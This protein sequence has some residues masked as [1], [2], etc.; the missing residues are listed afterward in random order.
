MKRRTLLLTLLLLLGGA[1]LSAQVLVR[2]ECFGTDFGGALSSGNPDF[3]SFG[4]ISPDELVLELEGCMVPGDVDYN[5]LFTFFI[6]EGYVLQSLQL[7][8][9]TTTYEW[10]ELN[11]YLWYGDNCEPNDAANLASEGH[12]RNWPDEPWSDNLIAPLGVLPSGYY[13]TWINMNTLP[14][15][16]TYELIFTLACADSEAPVFAT[17]AGALDASLDCANGAGLAAALALEPEGEDDSG[18]VSMELTG[19]ETTPVAGC[20]NAYTRVRTWTLLDGCGNSSAQSYTQTIEIYDNTPPTFPAMEGSLDVILDCADEDG[21]ADA[22]AMVPVPLDACGDATVMLM[23]DVTTPD[24]ECPN[25]YYRVRTWRA[26]DACG[27][28]SLAVFNQAIQVRDDT[29]PIAVANDGTIAISTPEGYNLKPEDVL[30]VDATFDA[31]GNV[32]IEI[33]PEVLGCEL[34]GQTVPVTVTVTDE[35]GNATEVVAMIEVTEDLGIKAP[36]DNDNIGATANGSATHSPCQG[37]YNVTS[38]GFSLPNSD[39]GHFVYVDLCGDGEIIARVAN[40]NP[41]NG[42]GGVMIRESLQ[43]GARK[44][45]LKTGLNNTIRR[46]IRT[47]A[48]M[49]FQ[50]QQSVMAPGA[51]WMRITRTGNSYALYVSPNGTAW[52]LVG[53]AQLNTGNC[54]LMGIYTESINNTLAVTA[55]FDQVTVSGGVQPLVALPEQEEVASQTVLLPSAYPNPGTGDF[56]IDLGDWA[57]FPATMTVTDVNGRPLFSRQLA[58]GNRLEILSLEHYPPG[59]YVVRIQPESGDSHVLKLFLK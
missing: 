53:N 46:E 52:Q 57:A 28:Q 43:P 11:L 21:L 26:V 59:M 19:D 55:Q 39:V 6:P 22:L 12:G 58:A 4:E 48:N 16:T 2:D 29:E 5:D 41:A 9:V 15:T 32:S 49:A 18:S 50:M 20:P 25:A 35:C 31:C 13:S 42:W 14:S 34:L 47:N 3:L 51:V 45:A 36:W 30:D 17:A 1:S 40:V 8:T 10:T 24:P 38:S 44:V 54:V 37:V 7:G 33:S 23:T 56:N 27:N